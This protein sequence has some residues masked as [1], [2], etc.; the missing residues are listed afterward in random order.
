MVGLIV[1][2]AVAMGAA[3]LLTAAVRSAARNW[4]ALDHPDGQRKLHKRLVPLWGGIA[5]YLA[6]VLG[7][8]VACHVCPSERLPL[9]RLG[10]ELACLAGLVCLVGAIDDRW[11]MRSRTKLVLQILSV[12]PLVFFGGWVDRITV[13]GVPLELGWLGLPLTLFWLVG[14]INAINLLDGMDGLASIVGLATAAMMGL[15]AAQEGH[16]HVTIAAT[17]LAGALA[18]FLCYN[19]PPASIFLGD[20][21]SMVIGLTVGLLGIEGAMKTSATLSITTPA[22]IMALPMFDVLLA[23]VRR[24]L[25]GRRFD[26]ADR[27]HIH[28]RLLDRGLSNWQVLC[29]AAV[30]C[31]L[32]GAAATA[33]SLLRSD[34]VAW[35][36]TITLVVAVI[37]LRLFGHHEMVLVKKTVAQ[38]LAR[39]AGRLFHLP[40]DAPPSPSELARL[41]LEDAWLLLVEEAPAWR[42]RRLELSLVAGRRQ[43]QHW[44]WIHPQADQREIQAWN[45]T[46]SFQSPQAGACQLRAALSECGRLSPLY[47]GGLTRLLK[48]FGRR[49][50]AAGYGAPTLALLGPL[51]A[52]QA[53][54]QT[55]E[56]AA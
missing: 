52:D 11:Q 46:V 23:V 4:G 34:M 25:T 2:F 10:G 24:R 42:V 9:I 26:A 13:F 21:G 56:E 39:L 22:V 17:V 48:A 18:G 44:T 41:S 29:I 16:P 53:W 36:V 54:P 8:A 37:R 7:L 1:S 12:A 5:V 30:F 50:A 43:N 40:A 31:L 49:F 28:H 33:A 45:V 27:E 20:S 19:L 38:Y 51:D 14:C 3:L 47:L 55:P 6:M 32:T 15:I 35:V